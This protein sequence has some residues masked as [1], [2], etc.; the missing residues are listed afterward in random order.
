[1]LE[2][3]SAHDRELFETGMKL[4]PIALFAAAALNTTA[5]AQPQPQGAATAL[6]LNRHGIGHLLVVPYFST[7]G[8][9]ATLL[10]L[11]NASN[12]TS[13]AVKIRFR[14]AGN[15][16]ELLSFQVF[17]R[18]RDAWTANIST[19]AGGL[20]VLTTTDRSCTL[21]AV[22]NG[23]TFNTTR[24]NPALTGDALA[25]QAREGSIEIIAMGDVIEATPL[26]TAMSPI[27]GTPP[28]TA[29][30]LNALT[31]FDTQLAPPSTGLMANWILINVPQTTTWSGEAVAYEARLNGQASTGNNVFFP[32]TATLLS[33]AD[34]ATY[35]SDPLYNF[36]SGGPIV[37]PS[38]LSLPDLSTP[39]TSTVASPQDQATELS[40]DIAAQGTVVEYLTDVNIQASTDW[41]VSMPTWRY[42]AAVDY[43]GPTLITN[44]DTFGDPNSIYFTFVNRSVS[45]S[46]QPCYTA[47][48]FPLVTGYDREGSST[49]FD[50]APFPFRIGPCGAVSV[51]SVS[52]GIESS[53][54][55]LHASATRTPLNGLL[56]GTDGAAQWNWLDI[57]GT[58]GLP[59]LVRTFMRAANPAVMP[60]VSGTFGAASA[61]RTS[62][63]GVLP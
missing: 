1:M 5:L 38:S 47:F 24:L 59:V 19:G 3:L 34:V 17:L 20:P 50:I 15:G 9:N 54:S 4:S 21:P 12:T 51:L 7:Q 10:N 36:D 30:V 33:S 27:L 46:G 52:G 55:T 60:G 53:S 14:G 56:S 13:K 58:K 35:T 48:T 2:R 18:P 6:E 41:V 22:V 26:R 28:C 8:G 45:A 42:H 32:Q 11:F 16:D 37:V 23:A 25:N 61:G 63:F 31:R 43:R 44:R 62:V 39:F 40:F 29:S 49:N 57:E